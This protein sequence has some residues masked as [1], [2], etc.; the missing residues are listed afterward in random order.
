MATDIDCVP[1]S[2]TAGVFL[3]LLMLFL[4]WK[5]RHYLL[6]TC[7]LPDDAQALEADNLLS[8]AQAVHS[9]SQGRALGSRNVTE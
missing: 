6:C 4:S 9:R 2:H 3:C 8:V 5:M 1:L 7:C